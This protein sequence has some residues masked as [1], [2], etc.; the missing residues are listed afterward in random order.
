MSALG[1]RCVLGESL[2]LALESEGYESL[3]LNSCRR[4]RVVC[5]KGVSSTLF[6]TVL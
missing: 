2:V 4:A 6:V 5:E 1:G 3:R